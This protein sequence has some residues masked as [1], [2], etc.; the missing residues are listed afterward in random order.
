MAAAEAP[1]EAASI[2]VGQ[3]LCSW[4]SFFLIHLSSY[5]SDCLTCV[6]ASVRLSGVHLFIRFKCSFSSLVADVALASFIVSFV[7]FAPFDF[8][9]RPFHFYVGQGWYQI[10]RF[11]T[12]YLVHLVLMLVDNNELYH[13]IYP[14]H[15]QYL[16]IR[17]LLS[18]H[19]SYLKYFVVT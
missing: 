11:I 9:N 6:S 10:S 12:F 13:K 8:S 17:P 7:L 3:C 15:L 14:F 19:Q 16:L 1:A 4:W 5:P 18:F 2:V